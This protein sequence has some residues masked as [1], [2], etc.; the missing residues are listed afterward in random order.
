MTA[1]GGS[2]NAAIVGCGN[3]ANRYAEQIGHYENIRLLGFS[4]IDLA[5]A[6][7]FSQEYGGRCYPDLAGILSD[8]EVDLVVN[9][10]IHHAHAEVITQCLNAGKHVHTEKP[11]ALKYD[12]A[13][14]LVKLAEERNLR[15]SS[16]PITYMGEAQQ[17]AWK[18]IRSGDLGKIR[19]AY[20]EVN[21]GRIET[22]HPN[23]EAFYDVGVL[24]DVSVYPLTLLTTFFG[25]A[26]NVRAYGRV[27]FPDRT[28]EDGRKFRITTPDCVLAAVEFPGGPL[29][30]LTASFY[31]K[32]S[33]QGASLEF[34]G[35]LARLYLGNFQS[36]N[37]PVEFALFG[38]DYE[39]VPYLRPPYEGIEFARGV[40][41]LA[42]AIIEDRPHRASAAHAAHVV[43]IVE[44]IHTAM[45]TGEVV[46]MTSTFSPP[47]PMDW[48]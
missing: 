25:P 34:H 32:G 29:V 2:V 17:T 28:T 5:R 23:P 45:R 18:L 48:A 35:D 21:H 37:T 14:G 13:A 19:L 20:A 31:A 30:R 38:E 15:L 41:D 6:E 16:A 44:G 12:E 9:L 33:K 36:F 22:W 1:N 10:T 3:I 46:D 4:D 27:L 42:E 26:E 43:E 11:L 7:A 39:D 47:P 8:P 40:Q 24:W